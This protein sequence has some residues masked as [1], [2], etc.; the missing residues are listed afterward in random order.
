[1]NQA[2]KKFSKRHL[3]TLIIESLIIGIV[4]AVIFVLLIKTVLGNNNLRYEMT[5]LWG[6]D[7]FF[8]PLFIL[9]PI[10]FLIESKSKVQKELK[11]YLTLAL[12]PLLYLTLYLGGL[13]V[14]LIWQLN[15]M[16]TINAISIIDNPTFFKFELIELTICGI[17][18][19]VIGMTIQFL[20]IKKIT[21]ANTRSYNI[22]G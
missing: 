15:G 14:D 17:L 5:N 8:Y 3:I 13:I 2:K 7:Y 20:W 9:L 11:K 18:G 6:N 4:G 22:G 19:I 16:A 1:V 12:F 21:I 10:S